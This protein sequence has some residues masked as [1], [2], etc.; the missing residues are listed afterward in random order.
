[1]CQFSAAAEAYAPLLCYPLIRLAL[2]VS[3]TVLLQLGKKLIHN[4]GEGD[5]VKNAAVVGGCGVLGLLMTMCVF[6]TCKHVSSRSLLSHLLCREFF[7][8]FANRK[9]PGR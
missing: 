9:T 7:N 4:A 2:L 5:N 3:L 8:I 6:T 1:L